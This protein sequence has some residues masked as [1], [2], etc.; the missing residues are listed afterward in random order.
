MKEVGLTEKELQANIIEYRR[1]IRV[2]DGIIKGLFHPDDLKK[3][4]DH[5]IVLEEKLH[6]FEVK[7]KQLQNERQVH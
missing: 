6:N 7:L 3:A 5:T 4:R 2:V 1:K